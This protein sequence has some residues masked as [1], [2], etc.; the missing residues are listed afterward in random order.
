[1]QTRRFQ[2]VLQISSKCKPQIIQ[3]DAQFQACTSSCAM[4]RI[5]NFNFKNFHQK[6]FYSTELER[7]VGAEL[8]AKQSVIDAATL[9][10]RAY[11]HF[12]ERQFT[13]SRQAFEQA[14]A[15]LEQDLAQQSSSPLLAVAYNNA[16]ETLRNIYS[17]Q[18]QEE[19]KLVA[20]SIAPAQQESN[21][22]YNFKDIL[23]LFKKSDALWQQHIQNQKNKLKF[24]SNYSLSSSIRFSSSVLHCF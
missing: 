24:L 10:K 14:I 7:L 20:S 8:A 4:P 12:Q 19:A 17:S 22:K 21:F 3:C 1:M 18:S 9:L 13:S 15:S 16:A 11:Q 6:R 5:S 23:P 2:H